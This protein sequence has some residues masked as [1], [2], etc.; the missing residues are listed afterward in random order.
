MTLLDSLRSRI[1]KDG[2]L[3]LTDA[4]CTLLG[5]ED[6]R[7]LN[8]EYGAHVLMRLPPR[9]RTF[10]EWLHQSDPAVWED[11]WADDQD[12]LVSMSH[13]HQLQSVDGGFLI[14]EL[15]SQRNYFFVPKLIKHRGIEALEQVFRK[16]DQ[17]KELAVGEVLLYEIVRKPI[18]IWHF[19]Y[20]YSI[21]IGTGKRAIAELVEQDCLTHLTQREDLA[22]YLESL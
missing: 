7:E 19:C 5:D 12:L 16:I 3:E 11:L 22:P 17:G 9:E 21:S 14:C 6:I 18:D 1:V 4:E 20:K 10:F 8:Q 15:E 13:L 2:F